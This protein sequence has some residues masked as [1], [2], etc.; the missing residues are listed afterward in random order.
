[1]RIRCSLCGHEFEAEAARGAC[2][3]CP[4]SSACVF[5]CCP[6]CGFAVPVEEKSTLVRL[7]DRIFP[8]EKK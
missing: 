2:G 7:F 4:L 3:H 5:S 1:M 6:R 8:S